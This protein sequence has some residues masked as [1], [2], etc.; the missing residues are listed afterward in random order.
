[1]HKPWINEITILHIIITFNLYSTAV[2]TEIV[3][4]IIVDIIDGN[5]IPFNH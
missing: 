2:N 3:I 4:T 5:N 1:M